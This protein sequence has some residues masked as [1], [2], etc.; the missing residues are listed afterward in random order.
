MGSGQSKPSVDDTENKKSNLGDNFHETMNY[1]ELLG[2]EKT[3]SDQELKK[4]YKKL[5]LK[6]H[7]DRN[8][9]NIDEA[10]ALF[11]KVQAAYDVLIDPQERAWYDSHGLM[12]GIQESDDDENCAETPDNV[13]TTNDLQAYFDPLIYYDTTDRPD[14]MFDVISKLFHQLAREE[15]VA[16]YGT[17]EEQNFDL[18]PS[19]G[20]STSDWNTVTKKFYDAWLGFSTNKTFDWH[21]IYRVSEASDRKTKRSMENENQKARLSAKTEFND[22]VRAL[23]AFVKKRDPRYKVHSKVMGGMKSKNTKSNTKA[24]EMQAA[25]ARKINLAKKQEYEEQKWEK[26]VEEVFEEF[27]S[28][29]ELERHNKKKEKLI[30]RR[31]KVRSG[32]EISSDEESNSDADTIE[33]Y[34]CVI[35]KKIFKTQKQ[36]AEHEKSKKHIKTFNKLRWQMKKEGIDI[37]LENSKESEAE[38]D[39]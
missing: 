14:S 16:L 28:E 27:M 1:Y 26:A 20:D 29:E 36:F 24:A 23:A 38:A 39:E 5:A 12:K 21:D 18:Y 11:A 13:T 37:E 31:K 15:L 35:C 4:V 22:T 7:P 8:F 25:K 17:V 6:L 33:F 2:V 32:E 10:T 34:E 3:A 30:D 19:F 9:D